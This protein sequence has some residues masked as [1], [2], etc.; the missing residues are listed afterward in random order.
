[1]K[2][3]VL[4]VVG[5]LLVL[6]SLV[7]VMTV[8]GRSVRENELDDGLS[9]AVDETLTN[10]AEK[11]VYPVADEKE[12]AADFCE[13]LLERIKTGT[14]EEGDENLKLQVDITGIDVEKGLLSVQVTEWFT[15]PNGKIG[16][17]T[18]SA[19]ALLDQQAPQKQ[20]RITYRSQGRIYQEYGIFARE[21][22]VVP[23]DPSAISGQVFAYWKDT[24]TGQQA[25]FP[26][27][28]T[29]DKTYEA[30]FVAQ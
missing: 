6:V 12:F 14:E 1:M 5:T 17:I 11:G 15:Y 18:K 22:F 7:A 8:M 4:G 16:S 9:A 20:Y 3:I 2:Q 26:D 27:T 19:T 25:Q 29:E 10:L 28:V 21:Q 30:V 13:A 24:D 23:K